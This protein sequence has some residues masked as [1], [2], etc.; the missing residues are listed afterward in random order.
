MRVSQDATT[1]CVVGRVVRQE[2]TILD[3]G[4]GFKLYPEV[5]V[6][7]YGTL[8]GGGGGTAVMSE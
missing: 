5:V 2:A 8:G 3:A 4:V 6:G 1:A 7:G